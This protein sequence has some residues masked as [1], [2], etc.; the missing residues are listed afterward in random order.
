MLCVF[1][2]SPTT[3]YWRFFALM[4]NGGSCVFLSLLP[5]FSH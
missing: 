3:R 4:S 2:S 5:F 1:V